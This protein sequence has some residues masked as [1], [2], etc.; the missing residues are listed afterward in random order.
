[1]QPERVTGIGGIFFKARNPERMTAWY[2]ENLGLAVQDQTAEFEW[3]QKEAPEKIGRTVW[4]VFGETSDYFG[5]GSNFMVNYQVNDLDR[6]LKQLNENGVRIEKVVD[7]E[8]GRFA[9]VTD[10]E[11]NRVELWEPTDKSGQTVS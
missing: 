2:R 3:R 1:M 11:G 8:Y 10:P 9:W 4:S 7:Y 5:A 6:M